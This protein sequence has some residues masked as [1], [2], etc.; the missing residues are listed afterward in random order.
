MKNLQTAQYTN[1]ITRLHR[2]VIEEGQQKEKY[3]R[4]K[5]G[6]D[7]ED[8]EIFDILMLSDIICKDLC[9]YDQEFDDSINDYLIKKDKTR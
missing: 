5:V 3:R 1:H 4:F 6:S 2:I 8:C 7:I 9:Y